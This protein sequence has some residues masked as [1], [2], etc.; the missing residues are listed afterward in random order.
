ME[1]ERRL[2]AEVPPS[3]TGCVNL[4]MRSTFFEE[5]FQLYE[6]SHVLATQAISLRQLTELGEAF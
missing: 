5:K 3:K 4:L 1:I 2:P 6:F